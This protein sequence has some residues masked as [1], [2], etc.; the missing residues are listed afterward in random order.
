MK[1]RISLKVA[2]GARATAFAGRFGDAWKLHV[3]A[4]PV[5]G[6]ANDAIT[7]FFARLLGLPNSAV[8]IVSGLTASRKTLEIEG[9]SPENLERAILESHG[10][11]PH[12]GSTSPRQT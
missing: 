5:D 2:A 3:A 1:T 12:T 9:I 7:K 4:P 11:R 6:K 10:P 8:R